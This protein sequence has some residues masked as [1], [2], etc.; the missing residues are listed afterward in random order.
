MSLEIVVAKRCHRYLERIWRRT[1]SPL[2]RSR[3][4]KQLHIC[5]HMMPKEKSDHYTNFISTNSE[6]PRHM[7]KSVNTN[8][9]R[10][11]LNILNILHWIHC[12]IL[13]SKLLAF[14]R[15]LSLTIMTMISHHHFLRMHYSVSHLQILMKISLSLK[16]LLT[17]RVILTHFQHFYQIAVSINSSFPTVINLSKQGDV[18]PRDFK[19]ALVNPLI[20]K[21]TLCKKMT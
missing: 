3:Y 2:D 7:W 6:N 16:S 4:T 1:R 5:N 12:V 15:I 17:N 11:K 21:Q 19:Q 18:V 9:N 13:F 14:H 20:K 10:Q 8:L